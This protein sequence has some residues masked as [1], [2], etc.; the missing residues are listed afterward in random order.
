LRFRRG[1]GVSGDVTEKEQRRFRTNLHAATALRKERAI[2]ATA[3]IAVDPYRAIT[4][5]CWASRAAH[6][7]IVQ[8]S[9][10]AAAPA[11]QRLLGQLGPRCAPR[12]RF[13]RPPTAVPVCR[14]QAGWSG[15]PANGQGH[16]HSR[17]G[18]TK[19]GNMASREIK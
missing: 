5:S 13:D 9:A 17:T 14:V 15:T 7:C 4:M 16:I 12:P 6:L 11:V 2:N 8:W 19:R 1:V 18:V 3:R 10:A